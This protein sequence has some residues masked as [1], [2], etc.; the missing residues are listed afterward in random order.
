MGAS[1]DVANRLPARPGQAQAADLIVMNGRITTLN[2]QR[3]SAAA[4]AVKD[5]RF[6]VVGSNQDVMALRG[7]ET[8][9]IDLGGRRVIPGLNDS[10]M[11][12]IRGGL[13]YNLEL[14]WDGV[15]SL[16]EGLK[17]IREQGQRTPEG[18]W[19]RVVGG[20][21][22]H[23]FREK[24]MPTLKE[25]NEAAPDTPVFVQYLYSRAL[26][27]QA[28][29][30]AVGYDRNTPNPPGGL[31]ERDASGNPTGLLIAETSGSVLFNTFAK[32]PKLSREDQVNSTRHFMR[33]LNRFGL[34]SGIDAGGGGQ[35]YPDNYQVARELAQQGLLT[36]RTAY[37][38]CAQDPD[39][40]RALEDYQQWVTM[41]EPGDDAAVLRVNGYVTEGG[42]E[43]LTLKAADFENFLE[44]QPVLA[45]D[46]EEALRPIIE[47]LVQK[48]WSFRI[49]GTY[50]ESITRFLDV[51]ETVDREIPFDGLRF[52]IDH[53]ETV[54]ERSLERIRALGGGVA[55]QSRMAYQGEHFIQRYGK[56]AAQA[57]PP[58][59]KMLDMGIPVG[60]GTD[61]TRV[62]TYNPWISLYWLTSGRS[63]GGTQLYGDNNRLSR[64]E[65]LR[66]Y[67]VGSAWFSGE[68]DIKGT[69]APGMLGDFAVLSDDFFSVSDDDI[70]SIE[71]VL[72]VVG[73]K[74]VYGAKAFKQLAEPLSPVSPN[75]SP[76]AYYGGYYRS[77]TGSKEPLE[78]S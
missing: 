45:P 19:V 76:V 74:V 17:M 65:A 67:T 5:G 4:L 15:P 31:I 49:H 50:D 32:A 73:G 6:L 12:H 21:S 29:L 61:A 14:R 72:T 16:A 18:Q 58:I 28:A 38:L 8:Q 59:R 62:S 35:V 53:A 1:K 48:R 47:L 56:E 51:F 23:Q 71:S 13:N 39:P 60:A 22:M 34:T 40:E 42:G 70:K 30:R 64:E 63:V 10:H 24:R 9:V 3:L 20:W 25:L 66:L 46:M 41:T 27:N 26:L 36:L 7:S 43:N 2:P 77:R 75:W 37:Y 69:I 52:A 44:P 68:E 78:L 57:A 55:V 33:E 54:S 11:H